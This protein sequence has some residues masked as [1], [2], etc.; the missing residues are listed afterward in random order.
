[1]SLKNSRFYQPLL[2]SKKKIRII[3]CVQNRQVKAVLRST[4]QVL[5]YASRGRVAKD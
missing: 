2:V 4:M 3:F 5:I 1:M